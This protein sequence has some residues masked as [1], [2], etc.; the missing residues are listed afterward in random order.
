M[1]GTKEQAYPILDR[2]ASATGV[3]RLLRR[4]LKGSVIV[5]M[6]HKVL[7]DRLAD[8]CPHRKLVI[9]ETTFAGQVAWLAKN[10]RVLPLRDAI[11]APPE[12]QQREWRPN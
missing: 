2:L 11:L 8:E 12:S 7:P 10:A 1:S 4:R 5:L 3:M 6:Y 9:R